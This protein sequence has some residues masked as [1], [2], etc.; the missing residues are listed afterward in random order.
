M[1]LSFK[2]IVRAAIGMVC[3]C[4]F[5][6]L[7]NQYLLVHFVLYRAAA[8]DLYNA[9]WSIAILSAQALI[10]LAVTIFLKRKYFI[11][12]CVIVTVSALVNMV[13]GQI[14]NDTL[15]AGK[16]KWLLE[17]SRQAGNAAGEFIGPVLIATVKMIVAL[18]AL[19]AARSFLRNALFPSTGLKKND[20]SVANAMLVLAAILPSVVLAFLNW[21]P[22]ASERNS[23]SLLYRVAMADPLPEKKPAEITQVNPVSAEKIIWLVDESISY[24]AYQKLIRPDADY[25]GAIDFGPALS[26]SSCSG[27]SNFALRSGVDVDEIRSTT[28][29]RKNP[30]IWAY[31]QKAG[32]Q[33]MMIDGQVSG[34]PQNIMLDTERALI[35]QYDAASSG[36]KTDQNIAAKLNGQLKS[37][38]QQ[39][40]YV[41]LKG[42]HF[43]YRDHYPAGTVSDSASVQ[44]QY[45]AAI[46][47]SKAGFFETLLRSIDREKVAIFY[48]ADHGQ[49][50]QEGKTPHCTP[51]P[52]LAEFKVPM[53][54]F[55]P[56]SKASEYSEIA[57]GQ[58]SASQLFASTLDLM[59][60]DLA[61][62]TEKYDNDLSLPSKK[63]LRFGRTIVPLNSGDEIELH[64]HQI[65]AGG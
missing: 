29:L 6:A 54:A 42:V 39:F 20:S 32:Y 10:L 55:L 65:L 1:S 58:R 18:I 27:P 31:A 16:F 21:G 4:V 33:T 61:T 17:E 41:V 26:L 63:P 50:I 60:Y 5:Y 2:L 23:Y 44:E 43:Q 64:E 56:P 53:A 15:D 7:V 57:T 40:I 19:I 13:Y 46:R 47:Y 12:L 49:N 22:E 34:P 62:A 14:L 11:A 28:D 52:P 24:T 59:G 3:F 37:H 38:E 9:I 36:L 8:N 30:S 35:D 51:N 45:E 25:Y 48:T